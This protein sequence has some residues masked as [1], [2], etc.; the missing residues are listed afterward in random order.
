[1]VNLE[2][3]IQEGLFGRVNAATREVLEANGIRVRP[4]GGQRCCGALHAHAGDLEGARRLARANVASFAETGAEG[5]CVNAAGCGAA[6]KGYGALLRDDPRYAE[7]ARDFSARVRDATELLAAA[8]PRPGAPLRTRVAYD[9]P[10]H[11]LHAQGVDA[12]VRRVLGAIPGLEVVEVERGEECCGGAGIYGITHPRLGG[13]IGGDKVAAVRA[14]GAPLVASGN[15][16]C[17]MQIGA[18]L[19]REGSP[20]RAVHPV[21]LLAESYR[22]RS[23][24]TPDAGASNEGGSP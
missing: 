10:C 1:M 22:R 24:S 8:G 17:M 3:C 6:L 23:G 16:G 20:V 12:P 2:G 21:E 5:V 18:G 15:P 14:T 4:W 7:A 9:P 13:D 11:L 19:L